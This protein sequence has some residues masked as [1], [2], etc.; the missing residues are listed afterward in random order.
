MTA[1]NA[2]T[3]LGLSR[4][5]VQRLRR[6]IET[7]GAAAIRHRAR[8]RVSNNRI[9]PGVRDYAVALVRERYADFGPTLAAEKLTEQH[10]LKVSR[11]TLRK[12]MQTKGIWLSRRQ[13]RTFHQPRLR[14]EALGELVQIDGSDHRWFEDRGPACIARLSGTLCPGALITPSGSGLRT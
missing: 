6:L 8:G 9:D 10:D 1:A 5:Q 3:L 4:R 2:A 13:R 7:E 14:R 11:E 12:W